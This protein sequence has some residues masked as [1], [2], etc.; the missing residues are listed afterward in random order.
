MHLHTKTHRARSTPVLAASGAWRLAGQGKFVT[1]SAQTILTVQNSIPQLAQN[2]QENKDD[3]LRI[4]AQG[5]NTLPSTLRVSVTFTRNN[6]YTHPSNVVCHVS[7][8]DSNLTIVSLMIRSKCRSTKGQVCGRVAKA[9]AENCDISVLCGGVD[10]GAAEPENGVEHP[11]GCDVEQQPIIGAAPCAWSVATYDVP[12]VDEQQRKT[13]TP[14]S[15]EHPLGHVLLSACRLQTHTYTHRCDPTHSLAN[16]IVR[17][18]EMACIL[19]KECKKLGGRKRYG[20]QGRACTL[21]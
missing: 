10:L 13:H 7:V 1:A 17:T 5:A 11:E 19:R 14:Q 4:D 3:D 20:A 16:S 18:H 8:A 15:V 9:M 21:I 6:L 12:H 2:I